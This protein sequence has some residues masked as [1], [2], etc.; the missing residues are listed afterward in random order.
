MSTRALALAAATVAFGLAIGSASADSVPVYYLVPTGPTTVP[1]VVPP[2]TSTYQLWVDPSG[3]NA[4]GCTPQPPGQGLP[5]CF[6][7]Y[8][9]NGNGVVANG[10]LT[11]TDFS[12]ITGAPA[13]TTSNLQPCPV[14]LLSIHYQNCSTV[15][16]FVAGDTTNGNSTPFELGTMTIANDG[17]GPGDITLWSADYVDANF[18]GHMFVTVPQTLALAAPEPGTLLLLGVGVGGLVAARARRTHGL[19]PRDSA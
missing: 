7:T 17:S 18:K 9:E 3:V 16:V 2:G 6:G 19:N 12:P 5:T 15:L 14:T 13:F 1:T 11:M 8:G 10:S 4:P